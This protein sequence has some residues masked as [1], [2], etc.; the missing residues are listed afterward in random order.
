MQHKCSGSSLKKGTSVHDY[1]D[2]PDSDVSIWLH[3][4]LDRLRERH[5]RTK[6]FKY[7]R[8]WFE[9]M[10]EFVLVTEAIPRFF[11]ETLHKGRRAKKRLSCPKKPTLA[12]LQPITA[13]FGTPDTSA[14]RTS[15]RWPMVAACILEICEGKKELWGD[16]CSELRCQWSQNPKSVRWRE[17]LY[18][19][20]ATEDFQLPAMLLLLGVNDPYTF[21]TILSLIPSNVSLETFLRAVHLADQGPLSLAEPIRRAL[22]VTVSPALEQPQVRCLCLQLL[23]RLS[24]PPFELIHMLKGLL[25]RALTL[26]TDSSWWTDHLSQLYHSCIF[27]GQSGEPQSCAI[28]EMVQWLTHGNTIQRHFASQVLSHS[29]DD[30]SFHP[31]LDY[32]WQTSLEIPR[33]RHPEPTW[34]EAGDLPGT[35]VQGMF[36]CF[37]SVKS[38][39]PDFR[40]FEDAYSNVLLYAELACGPMDSMTQSACLTALSVINFR[41]HGYQYEKL[42]LRTLSDMRN[43]ESE[44]VAEAVYTFRSQ[45]ACAGLLGAMPNTVS[46]AISDHNFIFNA[47]KESFSHLLHCATV[48]LA[49]YRCADRF[50]PEE[51][52]SDAVAHLLTGSNALKTRL[53]LAKDTTDS[54]AYLSAV[55]RNSLR[56]ILRA[57]HRCEEWQEHLTPLRKTA[58]FTSL[59]HTSI[60]PPE[61]SLAGACVW[62]HASYEM[63]Y[64]EIAKLLG[65]SK[66]AILNRLK[67]MRRKL[68][69]QRHHL[70]HPM[71]HHLSPDTTHLR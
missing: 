13:F 61:F 27:L 51:L 67:A 15:S 66:D 54:R 7:P 19:Q 65:L 42:A 23:F 5:P 2:Q 64:T 68:L 46:S 3:A 24:P 21:F 70:S 47:I 29:R 35:S 41:E 38:S 49:K 18:H 71:S 57:E 1:Y 63:R 9:Q 10:A 69:E 44:M 16:V 14:R 8:D 36:D 26:D 43:T 53:A 50:T 37:Q 48:W 28:R 12:D 33:W 25:T 34:E 30:V 52:V 6:W 60:V 22:L 55:V 4:A 39:S 32:V 58:L 56:D 31:I 17:W 40:N 59:T 20:M 62:W 45:L 11:P